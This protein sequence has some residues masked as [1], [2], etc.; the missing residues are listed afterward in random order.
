MYDFHGQHKAGTNISLG[1]ATKKVDKNAL[2]QSARAERMK[3]EKTRKE[4]ESA[5]RIQSWYRGC[6]IRSALAQHNRSEFDQK[7][8]Y[9]KNED[10]NSDLVFKELVRNLFVF[11]K[12][13][14]DYAR[15]VSVCQILLKLVSSKKLGVLVST[16]LQ[17]WLHR[18]QKLLVLCCRSLHSSGDLNVTIPLRMLEVFTEARTYNW[19]ES[20]QATKISLSTTVYLVLKGYFKDLYKLINVKVPSSLEPSTTPPTPFAAAAKDL[21]LKPITLLKKHQEEEKFSERSKYAYAAFVND[22]LS[23]EMSEQVCYFLVPAIAPA[24]P[25]SPLLEAFDYTDNCH[26]VWTLYSILLI[27]DSQFETFPKENVRILVH[28]LKTLVKTLEVKKAPNQKSNSHYSDSDDSDMEIGDDENLLKIPVNPCLSYARGKCFDLISSKQIVSV[29]L[30]W[31]SQSGPASQ[32]LTNYVHDL[33]EISF[34]L[35]S[36]MSL[37]VHKSVLLSTMAFNRKYLRL[38]WKELSSVSTLSISGKSTPLIHQLSLGYP[39]SHD[40][41][42]KIVPLLGSFAVLFRYTLFSLYD[43]DFYNEKAG[44]DQSMMPF[45]LSEVSEMSQLLINVILGLI[46][47]MYPDIKVAY[48]NEEEWKFLCD[49]ATQLVKQLYSR[50]CRHKFCPENHW[51]SSRA[52]I[53]IEN[54]NISEYLQDKDGQDDVL[55]IQSMSTMNAR[56]LAILKYIPF[57]V[58]FLH[59]VEIFQKIISEDRSQFQS[60]EQR[61]M[62]AAALNITVNRKYLYQDA[63]DQL[64]QDRTEDI[65]KVIRVQMVNAQGLEE[66]GI[67]GGGVFREFMSQLV[68]AGFD[69]SVG[70]FKATSQQLLYPNPDA[71]VVYDDYLKHLHFLGRMLGKIVYESMMVELPLAEFFLCKLLNRYGSDVDIYHLES[72][73]PELY[74]NLLYLKNY[75]GDAD[76]LSLNFTVMNDDY[77]EA[78]LEELKAGGRDICVTNA[79]KIE[80]IHLVADY[81]LN[82]QIRLHV[83]AFR[84]GLSNVISIEWLQMFDH[85]ELQILISG[86]PVPI[87]MEDLRAHTNYSGE[88]AP[89]DEYILEFWK[90]V[91]N[92]TE[93]QKGQFLKFVTSCSRPPLLGFSDLYPKF[94]IHYGGDSEERLP[95]ASTCMN[96]LKLPRYRTPDMLRRKLVYAIEAE[97]G[98]ELS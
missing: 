59:R 17:G 62:S 30:S 45:S 29:M 95:T 3:R 22:L 76:D 64:A 36:K 77:G 88:F 74:K 90:L 11:Y 40:D 85:R 4:H 69:P 93:K 10:E 27:L 34:F 46:C 87:D 28:C 41:E 70:F 9:C 35:L 7:L 5:Q 8:A 1:G 98:F 6:N 60:T 52:A 14:E 21:V 47:F 20:S 32:E 94:C 44:S 24:L 48:T 75:E 2:I 86:A 63:F 66:A 37:P 71:G 13:A 84:A 19:L 58:P 61:V 25:L 31:L 12:P 73:D 97:A 81:R 15:L 49:M 92:F 50:D 55:P 26:S 68:K 53:T 57:A 82:K 80:Y 67:D 39:M 33:S 91:S 16:D 42:S 38:L 83:N 23:P 79:N 89:D 54:V 18:F 51:L 96:F 56:N 43:S 72:L 65:K 78:K